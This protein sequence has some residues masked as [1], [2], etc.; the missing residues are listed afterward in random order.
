[1]PGCEGSDFQACEEL[2]SGATPA[3][4]P[5]H[6]VRI[7]AAVIVDPGPGFFLS[8]DGLKAI[9]VPLQL[10][11]SDPKLATSYVSGCCSLGIRSRLPSSPDFHLASNAIHFSFLPPCSP[12]EVTDLP[13]ICIDAPGFDRAVFHK[14]FNAAIFA[15]LHKHLLGF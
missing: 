15:F 3:E 8:A 12:Q 4:P 10:W 9:K 2:R 11:S 14:D 6:D 13:R 1:L 7:K 5:A